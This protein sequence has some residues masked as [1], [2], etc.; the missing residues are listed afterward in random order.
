MIRI[1]GKTRDMAH[2][3]FTCPDSDEKLV[4]S[5]AAIGFTV[6]LKLIR[7]HNANKLMVQ[8]VAILQR[9]FGISVNK[10]KHNLNVMNKL[11]HFCQSSLF[12]VAK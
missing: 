4:Y 12:L 11:H 1:D 5:N 10:N 3:D 7:K 6:R 9:I 2:D 8:L